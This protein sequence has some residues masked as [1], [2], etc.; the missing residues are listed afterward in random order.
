MSVPVHERSP[1]TPTHPEV[2]DHGKLIA[3]FASFIKPQIYLEYGVAQGNVIKLLSQYAEKVIGVDIADNVVDKPANM[4]LYNMRTSDFKSIL[5][6]ENMVV[7]MAFID[8]NHNHV[9]VLNDFRDIY[10]HVIGNGFIFLH[11]TYPTV[12]WLTS[13]T[14]CSDSWMVPDMIKRDYPDCEVLTIPVCPGLT[15]V[16]KNTVVLPWMQ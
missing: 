7:D 10:P 2:F 14:S 5:I 9:E 12:P 15:V 11:D 8:A 16:R 13:E 4:T 1:P 6:E 3:F